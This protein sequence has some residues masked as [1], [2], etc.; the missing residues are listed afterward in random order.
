MRLFVAME[1]GEEDDEIPETPPPF[2]HEADYVLRTWLE[3]KLHHLYPE[4]GGYNDQD[5]YLM[6]DWHTVNLYYMRAEKGVFTAL[7]VSADAG[8][9]LDLMG[10]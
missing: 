7:P 9:W 1:K 2:S 4:S 8:S 5:P 6:K 10:G 3:H